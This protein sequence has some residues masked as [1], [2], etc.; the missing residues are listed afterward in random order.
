MPSLHV[1]RN[2]FEII[3]VFYFAFN[4]TTDGGYMQNKTLKLFWGFIS[5]VTTSEIISATLNMLKNIRE[6]Q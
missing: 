4:G 5:H 3:S 1:K 2:Y 6:L